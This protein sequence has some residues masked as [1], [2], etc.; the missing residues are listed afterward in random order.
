[1]A[2][3]KG[4]KNLD[5]CRPSDTFIALVARAT[6]KL[7]AFEYVVSPEE[8]YQAREGPDGLLHGARLNLKSERLRVL[9]SVQVRSSFD[10]SARQVGFEPGLAQIVDRALEG[11][12]K[13]SEMAAGDSVRMVAQELALLGT[14]SRYTGIEAIEY[15]PRTGEPIRLYYLSGKDVRGYVDAKGRR[16]G[17]GRWTNP[18]K[19]VRITS[20]FNPKRFHPI[21]KRIRPHNGTDFAAPIG[22]PVLAA[23]AGVVSFMGAAGPN[24]NLLKIDHAGGYETGY[25]HLSRFAKGLKRGARV[26][27]RQVIGFSGSTGRSTGPHLHFSAKK[28]GR[29]IDPETL[30]LDEFTRLPAADRDLMTDLRQR[31][32]QLLETVPLPRPFPVEPAPL[33]EV[34][35][36]EGPSEDEEEGEGEGA[37]PSAAPAAA[38]VVLAATAESSIRSAAPAVVASEPA[39]VRPEPAAAPPPSPAAAPSASAAAITLPPPGAPGTSD[40]AAQENRAPLSIFLSDGELLRRQPATHSGE[41]EP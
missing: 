40:K 13:T 26:S 27:Q 9:G 30:R 28:N 2:A 29:F 12:A 20:R 37:A 6:G 17:R 18:V 36:N 15:R 41:V 22:T 1:M 16:F 25:S 38:N 10:E 4:E 19:D 7:R 32:D 34:V 33:L 23:D 3:L 5:K 24:G 35:A 14:F 39:A 11:Y 8:V 21:L 31:Y